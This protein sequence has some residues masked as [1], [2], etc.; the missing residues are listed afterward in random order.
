MSSNEIAHSPPQHSTPNAMPPMLSVFCYLAAIV[1]ANLLVSAA[2]AEGA[3]WAM[4][5]IAFTLI[6]LDLALRDSL[7]EA[8]RGNGLVW[9]MA[10]LIIA[11]GLLSWLINP[12]SGQIALASA[13]AFAGGA[14]AD[15]L[16]WH[17]ARKWDYLKRANASNVTG[18]GVDS[19]LF[20]F[21]AFGAW[22]PVAVLGQFVAKAAGGGVWSALIKRWRVVGTTA[23]LLLMTQ[24]AKGQVLSA[25][26]DVA[27]Q[28]PIASVVYQEPVTKRLF[29]NGFTEVWWNPEEAF[30]ANE[31]V[32]F[33]KHWISYEIAGPL[34]LSAEIEVSRNMAGAFSRWPRR[35]PFREDTWRVNP[36][37]G[38]SVN[39]KSLLK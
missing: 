4:P 5:L 39:L 17:A 29:V 12:A 31:A 22:L 6:G 15:A 25:H 21:L 14:S 19:F 8:W 24:G 18:A 20:P 37:I 1:T 30:P 38:V 10:A 32:V 33:S 23:V 35:V 7:H 16:V 26:Y 3:K 28:S 11:G 13:L 36:K 27:R 2:G 9:K 34:S